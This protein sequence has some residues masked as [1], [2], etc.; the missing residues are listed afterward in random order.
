MLELTAPKA[1]EVAVQAATV[2]KRRD[3]V[4]MFTIFEFRVCG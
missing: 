4:F 1:I 2:A 3:L